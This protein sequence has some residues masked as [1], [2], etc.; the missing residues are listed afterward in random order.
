MAKGYQYREINRF[1]DIEI[2]N[3]FST[4]SQM[5]LSLPGIDGD[6]TIRSIIKFLGESS[7]SRFL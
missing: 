2:G 6:D 4:I 5:S 7:P 1:L 3:E